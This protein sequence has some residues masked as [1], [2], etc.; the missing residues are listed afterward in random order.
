MR[1]IRF[2]PMLFVLSLFLNLALNFKEVMGKDMTEEKIKKV[3][4]EMTLEEKVGQ[5]TQVTLE[6]VSKRHDDRAFINKLDMAK[7]RDAILKY[8]VGSILNC[9]GAANTIDNWHEM[10]TTMQN[11]ALKESRLKIPIIYG[12]DAIHGNNYTKNATLFPQAISMAASRNKDLMKKSGEITAYEMRASGIGWNFYPVLDMGRQPLWSRFWETFGEDVYLTS[13]M[14]KAYIE[15]HQGDDI[16]AKDKGATCL[17]HYLGYSFPLNGH[18]RTPAWIPERM[19]REIFLPPFE[20]AVQAGAMTVMVNSAEINGIPTHSDYHIL[21]EILKE[22][23]GF[24]G[25]VVSD[26]EDIKRLHTRDRVADSPKEAVRMAV[27]AGLDMSMV[28]YDFSFYDQ[29]LELVN[30]G[31]VPMSR[32]DDAVTRILRV[33]FMLG[34]F[35]SAYP[36][37]NLKKNFACAEF[38]KANLQAA[39]E[40]ITLLK[41]DNN[42]LPLAKDKKVLVTGP[43]ANLLSVMNGGWTITW[44]GDNESLYPQEK[45]TVL[46]AIQQKIGSANVE[47]EAVSTFSE[48]KDVTAAVQKAQAADAVVL[49]LGEKNYCET[50]G[51]I[52]NLTLDE[53][54]LNL[55]L[56]LYKTGKPV[57][58]LLIEGRPRVIN[59]IVKGAA[60]I[61]MAYLPG[62]EGGPAIADVLFGDVNPSGKL[63]F[64]YPKNPNGYTTYDYKPLEASDV[65]RYDPQFPFG[66]GLSYTSFAYSDLRLEK[67]EIN[68]N[69]ALTVSVKV[70]NTGKLSGKE[71]V[72]LYLT[73]LFGSVSRPVKQLKGFEKIE[74]QADEEKEVSF[75]LNSKAFSF[76]GREDKRI[77]EPGEFVVSVGG[78]SDK[79]TLK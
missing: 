45:L 51:N 32:I 36:D 25:L 49:C 57:V 5:M 13:Q 61:V 55:A 52:D 60:A 33:K 75:S 67:K 4:L 34:L 71:T 35:D 44:Q 22:E 54:Q 37:K 47:Y 30:E 2:L 66:H 69:Q 53:A 70:K 24:K 56:E 15:G 3:L 26:W 77:I 38:T 29:L 46:E 27:M 9:G 17:K 19:I 16:G 43:T 20:E 63:P 12:I 18:D 65:N 76:I 62:M 14:G 64:S 48:L 31:A 21:T 39:Q 73:D 41:N 74:L 8:H 10:I 59:E 1:I 40:V 23:L 28:P 42:T 78:L 11:I 79:F 68:Q 6:V 7:L 50:P 58:L 72:E